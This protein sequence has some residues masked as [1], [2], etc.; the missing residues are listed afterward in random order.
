MKRMNRFFLLPAVLG[1]LIML[2]SSLAGGASAGAQ[3]VNSAPAANAAPGTQSMIVRKAVGFDV[4]SPLRELVAREAAAARVNPAPPQVVEEDESTEVMNAEP[5]ARRAASAINPTQAAPLMPLSSNPFSI[6]QSFEG[7]STS[8]L[9]AAGA[10]PCLPTPPATTGNAC[11]VDASGAVG[12]NHYFQTVNFAFSIYDK[13]GKPLPLDGVDPTNG[14]PKGATV[15]PTSAFWNGFTIP[16]PAGPGTV[17]PCGLTWTDVVVLYDHQADRWFVSRFA[18]AFTSAVPNTTPWYQCF[19]ISKTSDPTGAYY[20]YAFQIT[21]SPV[22]DDYPKFGIWPDGYYMTARNR[23]SNRQNCSLLACKDVTFGLFVAAFERSKMLIG[24]PTAQMVLTTVSN[25]LDSSGNPTSRAGMLPAD[26]DGPTPPPAGTPN[27]MVR[28]LSS[29][30]GWPSPD[31]LQVY[32][33]HVDWNT[34][35]NSTLTPTDALLPNPYTPA[36]GTNQFCIPQPST[37]NPNTATKLDPMS[38]VWGDL[39]YRLVYRNFI[40]QNSVNHEVLLLDHTV[41]LNDNNGSDGN[42]GLAALHVAPQ[43]YELHRTAGPPWAIFQQGDYAPD[44]NH[45]W[46]GSMGMDQLGEIALGYNISGSVF[47]SIGFA[48]RTQTDQPGA[49]SQETVIQQGGGAMTG[50]IFLSDYSQLTVDPSDDCT[51]WYVNGYQPSTSAIQ[52][53][54][55]HIASFRSPGCPK[56]ATALTYTGPVAANFNG[57]VTLS[58]ILTDSF[59]SGRPIE[60]ATL[61]FNV[62][63]LPCIAKTDF[64]GLGSCN[65]TLTQPAGS[66]PLTVNYGGTAQYLP[67]SFSGTFTVKQWTGLDIGNP[68]QAGS[69][70]LS[71]GVFTITGGGTGIFNGPDEFHY[72]YQSLSGDM[73]IMAH[74]VSQTETSSLAKAG[75]MIRESTAANARFVDVVVT[76]DNGVKM[77]YRSTTGGG[78]QA[79]NVDGAQAPYWLM[80]VRTGNTFSGYT[81]PDNVTWNLVGTIHISMAT[82]VTVGLAVTATNNTALS[83][84]TFDNVRIT[85]PV[86]RVNSGGGAASPFS[87]DQFFSGGVTHSTSA[88]IDLSGVANPAPA[89]VYQTERWGGDGN[90]NDA[91]FTYTF[92]GL[93]PGA[94]YLVRL[95]FAEI[96]F[97]SAGQRLFNVTINGNQVLTNFDVIVAA[98][99]PDAADVEEFITT[100]D[101]NGNIIIT[102]SQGSANHAKSSGIEIATIH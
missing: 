55:T 83:T 33:F 18:Q 66:Y 35:A 92:P 64:S 96:H 86:Y 45:R 68:G 89:A 50:S 99:A 77:Q 58:A 44:S 42:G 29:Q 67:S 57:Q 17:S 4:S 100:A 102:Y 73:T 72:V 2:F 20:R 62:G 19:A 30:L 11:A 15:A 16:N 52:N 38:G 37:G 95:H 94:S 36:C 61:T 43:W 65:I 28:A 31:T 10:G 59:N 90:G 60:G 84:A 91:P 97:S 8:Q 82:S 87:A 5:A 41:D 6:L 76:S 26:W 74:V 81:S 70:S 25:L 48:G 7:I 14:I 101:S 32:E 80:L 1:T 3:N 85:T 71:S 53:W 79:G 78:A 51:L 63:S 12:P 69:D 56:A 21:N 88:S 24:D 13:Q 93:A 34:P 49:L 46:M 22:F 54:N 98:G 23:Y 47:P 40:D 75:V 39:M 9:S 27:Y